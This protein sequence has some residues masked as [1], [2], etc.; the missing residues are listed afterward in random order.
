MPFIEE[1]EDD[2]LIFHVIL[3]QYFFN[4]TSSYTET[5][6]F[7]IKQLYSVFNNI[8][9]NT[10]YSNKP[11][12]NSSTSFIKGH[13]GNPFFLTNKKDESESSQLLS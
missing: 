2:W 6:K 4:K 3:Y 13:I 7:Q 11:M 10:K 9:S 1:D 8:K 5:Y 12:G